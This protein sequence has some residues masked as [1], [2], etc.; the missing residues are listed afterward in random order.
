[1][2]DNQQEKDKQ[3]EQ[4][5]NR[6]FNK[7]MYVG[8]GIIF[9]IYAFQNSA[10][11]GVNEMAIYAGVA[12]IIYAFFDNMKQAGW[13]KSRSGSPVESFIKWLFP[14]GGANQ[15]ANKKEDPKKKK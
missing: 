15:P 12:F 8:I 7:W 11:K 10:E 6:K 2:A 5:E 4:E 3:K 1:M 13:F 14:G 9:I